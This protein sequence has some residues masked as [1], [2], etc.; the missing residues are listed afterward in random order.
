MKKDTKFREIPYNYTSF[1]DR[2]I[3]YKYF[4]EEVW[5][6]LNKLREERVTGRSAKLLFEVIGDYF[7]I[8]RNP[9]IFNDYLEKP[10]KLNKLKKNHKLRLKKIR[11]G[12]HNNPLVMKL[13][14][15]CCELEKRFVESF[16]EEKKRNRKIV[17]ALKKVTSVENIHFSA[18]HKVSHATDASDWRAEYPAAVVYPASTGEVPEI[19]LAA[20][21][22]GLKI[23]PRGGGTGL[24]GGAV[25]VVRDTLVVNTEKL[26]AIGKIRNELVN[27]KQVPVI[28]VESGA[29]TEDVIEYCRHHG[30]I[31]ATDP[32]SAWASTIGGNIAENAGGKKCVM[33]GTA[34]DNLLSY[35][36]ADARGHIIEVS[37]RNHPYRKILPDDEVVFDITD[38]TV[39]TLVKS[40]RL[41]GTE[42]RKKGLGKDITNK[43]LKGLP[44]L[45]K[46]G[47]DGIILGATFVL[48]RPFEYCRTICLEF[49]GKNLI[50][51]SRAI[52]DILRSFEDNRTVFLT[53]LEHFDEKYVV[54]INYRNKSNRK[55]IPKAVLLID[56]E[57]DSEEALRE[58][59]GDILRNVKGY[60]TEGFI[61]SDE[62]A[63]DGFWKDRKNLGAIAR[64]TNAFKLNE[65]IVIPISR[66]PE[67]ADFIEKLNVVKELGN[68]ARILA[69]LEPFLEKT[70]S[71]TR[72][73][74]LE[75]KLMTFL[76]RAKGIRL[77]YTQYIENI[78]APA[79]E[80]FKY[81]SEFA[82]EKRSVFKLIQEDII[83][84]SFNRDVIE[85]F[86]QTFKGYEDVITGFNL[87]VE[88]ESKRKIIVATHMHAGDGNVHV[89][90][91]VHSNDYLMMQEA[92]ETAGTVMR[93]AVRIGGVISGEHG[94]GLTKLRFIDREVL[95]EF[96]EYK[97]EADPDDLFNPGKL[98]ANFPLNRVYTPSFNLLELEAFIL[99]AVDLEK[100]SSSIAPCV[101]CGK[102]K[103]VCNTHYPAGGIFY[104]PRNK[105][106]G[107]A[108]I[109][110]AVLFDAQTS[111][112]LSFG[113][114][115]KLREISDHCTIC[116][117]C[118]VPC[119]V[120][121]DFGAVTLNIRYLLM[122]RKKRK[123]KPVTA[124]TLYYLRQKGY[125]FNKVFRLLLLRMGY[126][127]QRM[128]YHLNRPISA[129]TSRV[130]PMIN[131]YLSSK[132]PRAG[133][134]TLREVVG[135]RGSST[136]ISFE[137]R[138]MPVKSSVMYFPGCGSER[139]FSDISMAAVA[140]LYSAGVRV[141]M[142]PEYLCCGYPFLANGK[143]EQAELKSYDNRV[144]FHKMA[145]IISYMEISH[146]LV[147]CGTCFE[148]LEKYEMDNIF[149]DAEIMD[150]SE[151]IVAKGLYSAGIAVKGKV[152]YH[153]PC[154][155]PLKHAGYREV[156]PSLTG[157]NA[158]LLP[159]CCGEGGT[160]ALSTPELSNSLRERKAA[161][162]GKLNI[163]GK[164]V[165]L[166]TCPS[167][168]QGLSRLEWEHQVKVKPLVV[169]AAEKYLGRDWKK[170]FLR[171]I[172]KGGH[173]SI[174]F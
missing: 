109:I 34:I 72:D 70:P 173:E 122:E 158:R 50:N 43:A 89:N 60:N 47:G 168:V 18:F 44:G 63:R 142:P 41:S 127:F 19:I 111:N 133:Q 163:D 73:E 102:C 114:F 4:D 83:D 155:T 153:D 45:Q 87:L 174:I 66:L 21:E 159:F 11:E 85:N 74:F 82:N 57:S 48:Y 94:I 78:D 86:Y 37:R 31:F 27:W 118:Q 7:I 59:C 23:I 75:K 13:L 149:T 112:S 139:M 14:D 137:N 146:V 107:V 92:D 110:E 157:A 134:K 148:M 117:K 79:R 115:K 39:K 164:A 156:I 103:S 104:N 35:R 30:Y 170:K 22:T 128:G 135:V 55:D 17:N 28:D 125:Y 90:I 150:V 69:Q 58:A 54:A 84:I 52:V 162:L 171:E 88:N 33:W 36:I 49:F 101:R 121:I 3:I 123:F 96:A 53:A 25:P 12:S 61:A 32:T 62:A 76:H 140:L 16:E 143:T 130:L 136:F 93:E 68:Y 40:I 129:F 152:L 161:D 80:L 38:T 100:L 126:S 97:K 56:V 116:H 65:D 113:H 5:Q 106:F 105:I 26:N 166:T 9:Y 51:A 108:L 2:E 99:R 29:V 6:I 124:F 24:T 20:A 154:H 10:R 71:G 144:K 67:F 46:E 145:N 95:Q 167:C 147:T 169:Y 81:Q 77:D 160:M 98:S 131:G 141:V 151:F 119:P 8:D 120:N 165:V 15:R 42:I 91:P 1:S 132:L 138:A 64:H 172:K